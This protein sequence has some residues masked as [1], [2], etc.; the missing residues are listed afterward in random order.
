[1]KWYER[2]K[3]RLKD[4]GLTQED[5]IAPLNVTTRGAVGHYLN[6]RREPSQK[7]LLALCKKLDCSL[8]WLLTGNENYKIHKHSSNGIIS[9]NQ[10]SNAHETYKIGKSSHVPVVGTAQL[11]DN[12][13]W[14][15]LEYPTGHGDGFVLFATDDKNA[16][17]LR[18]IGDSM[19]P[20]IQ[21][22]EY[23]VAEPNTEAQPGDEVIVKAKD[24]RIMVKTLLYK[25]EDRIHL[26]SI[27]EAHPPQSILVSEVEIMHPISAIV[28]RMRWISSD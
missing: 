6:G 10:N 16:Y 25:R 13:Y 14:A 17:A 18:C 7:Q 26:I 5:I 15:E 4:Q 3:N 22:G 1:M 19:K 11:G 27:N 8:D 21:N 28:K 2:A 20:R 9:E 12:G 23:V 24:G